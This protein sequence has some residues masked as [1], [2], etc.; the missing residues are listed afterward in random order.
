MPVFGTRPEAIKMA[1]I[2]RELQKRPRVNTC[3]C[4]T[5][6]HKEMLHQ[7]LG[8]FDIKPTFD[9]H[10][11]KPRQSLSDVT[12]RVITAFEPILHSERPDLVLVQGDTTTTMT[13]AMAAYYG[14][15]PIGHVEAGLRTEDKRSP[16]PEEV[17]RRIT[18]VLADYHFCPTELTK[19][20]LLKENINP[21]RIFVT[22]NTV[23][24]ALF[25]GLGRIEE[26]PS[27]EVIET[28]ERIEVAAHDN[29]VVLIT[30]HRRESFGRPL[31]EMCGAVRDLA[32]EHGDVVFVYPTHLN[33]SVREVVNNYLNG[34]KN[35]LLMD[36]IAYLPFIWLMKRSSIILTDSGGIQ[37]EAP[38]LGK[39]VLVMR[40]CTERP[41][42]LIAGTSVLVGR[43]RQ[44]IYS[45]VHELLVNE[46]KYCSI[47]SKEN[48]FG[49]G[50]AAQR[51]TEIILR[52]FG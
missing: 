4:V 39:P 8:A 46:H 26:E 41:E 21:D 38:S 34:R 28:K 17:N 23:V 15:I 43:D 47:S 50:K 12:A 31:E 6:Q 48:P 25:W 11:M 42:G 20:N 3:V 30:A 13:I 2:I 10:V 37:E 18:S 14:G 9:L 49:D 51:I 32:E 35:I 19:Q 16:F 40:E 7:V 52:L 33:P 24:D 36:P 44:A 27:L 1:P 29:R 22:G 45:S 5:S